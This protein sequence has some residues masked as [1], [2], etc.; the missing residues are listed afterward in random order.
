MY[1]HGRV[2]FLVQAKRRA[3]IAPR[4]ECHVASVARPPGDK[5]VPIWDQRCFA[6]LR[7][8]EKPGYDLWRESRRWLERSR[9][10]TSIWV[11]RRRRVNATS[12]LIGLKSAVANRPLMNLEV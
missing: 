11:G 7:F 8:Y 12:V 5:G 3:N 9:L 6:L 10:T 2:H 1:G 4:A